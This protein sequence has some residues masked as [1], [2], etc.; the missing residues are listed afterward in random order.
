MLMGKAKVAAAQSL[1]LIRMN[2]GAKKKIL[3]KLKA[4]WKAH[5]LPGMNFVD[6][7]AALVRKGMHQRTKRRE[8]TLH[9]SLDLKKIK[10]Y[11][12]AG[13]KE[14]FASKNIFIKGLLGS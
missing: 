5:G 1:G 8:P 2:L 11:F 12:G 3:A 14:F 9:Q 6:L 13:E 10:M 7:E 4:L